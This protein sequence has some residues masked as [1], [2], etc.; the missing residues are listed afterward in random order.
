MR[1]PDS[2]RE[3]REES[4]NPKY[5]FHR[6][7]NPPPRPGGSEHGWL[8]RATQALLAALRRPRA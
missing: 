7:Q 6:V 1:I 8:W 5:V 2:Q 3:T 4:D